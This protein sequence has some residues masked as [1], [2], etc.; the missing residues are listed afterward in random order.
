M[1]FFA[2]GFFHESSSPKPPKK[3]LRSFQSFSKIYKDIHNSRCT[4]GIKQP[5]AYYTGGKFATVTMPPSVSFP[6]VTLV[7]LILVVNLP[8]GINNTGSKFA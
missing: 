3:T 5:S 6:P 7:I 2:S 4:T 8:R 1:G